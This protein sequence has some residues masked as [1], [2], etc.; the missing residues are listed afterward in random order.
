MDILF[1]MVA[2]THNSAET[3]ESVEKRRKPVIKSKPTPARRDPVKRREQ[4]RQSQKTYS[5]WLAWH[6]S[7][8]Q[9]TQPAARP[10]EVYVVRLGLRSG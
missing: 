6:A 7:A 5:E 3:S 10:I 9:T 8:I 1:N 2:S 4:N